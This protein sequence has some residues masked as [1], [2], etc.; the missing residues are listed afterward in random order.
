MTS[1]G[2]LAFHV[3]VFME[4]WCFMLELVF[5]V[6][7]IFRCAINCAGRFAFL[8]YAS[9]QAELVCCHTLQKF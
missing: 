9:L 8:C 5:I 6:L 4:G 2:V 3:T 7:F 1:T